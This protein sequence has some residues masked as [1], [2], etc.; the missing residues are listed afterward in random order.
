VQAVVVDGLIGLASDP[1]A[2]PA[3]RARTEAALAGLRDRLTDAGRAG[4]GAG[5]AAG[6]AQ[7]AYLAREIER[8]LGRQRSDATPLTA[9][10]GAPPGSPIGSP[11]LFGA[12]GGGPHRID[13]IDRID[14][15]GRG[16]SW[17]GIFGRE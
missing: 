14:W 11:G 10:A 5:G 2:S 8:H 9:A 4:P 13:R 16:C 6:A 17:N 7:D 3:V 1:A 12:A 15:M